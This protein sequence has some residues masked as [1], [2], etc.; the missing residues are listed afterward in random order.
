MA[1][2]YIQVALTYIRHPF[3]RGNLLFL[4]AAWSMALMAAISRDAHAVAM[5]LLLALFVSINLAAHMVEQFADSR[6]HLLPHFRRVHA[7][8]AAVA[9]FV[10]ITVLPGMLARLAGCSVVATIAIAV[11]L[12]GAGLWSLACR[13]APRKGDP[14][15]AI[16]GTGCLQLPVVWLLVL[17]IRREFDQF[18]SGQLEVQAI[19]LDAIVFSCTGL[20]MILLGA[21]QLFRLHDASETRFFLPGLNSWIWDMRGYT[22]WPAG[23]PRPD[24]RSVG[25]LVF[26]RFDAHVERL[27]EHARRAS[28]SRWSAVCR[29][30]VGT[31][32]GWTSWLL[33]VGVVLAMQ[34]A[35]WVAA[36]ER[37]GPSWFFW[38]TFV[39]WLIACPSFVSL[40]QLARRNYLLAYEIMLPVERRTYLKQV[41]MAAAISCLRTW[42]GMYAAFMLWWI[43]AA[44]E[45]LQIGLVVNVLACSALAQVGLFGIG[46]CLSWL[47]KRDSPQ[48]LLVVVGAIW[49]VFSLPM[50]TVAHMLNESPLPG[51]GNFLVPPAS[52]A[53]FAMF[54]LLLTWFVYRRWL[55][56][57]FD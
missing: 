1:N 22:P 5:L 19:I 54:G 42:G 3:R 20:V 32:N 44:L 40:G 35:A 6:A 43:T 52:A 25:R 51:L 13:F 33:G 46:L 37:L 29:W 36:G 41:G 31:A 9:T 4:F 56:E 2:P 30:R 39:V 57:D 8:V 17:I 28:A 15:L 50:L 27:I 23:L 49:G 18:M 14:L 24:E 10:V 12:F 11:S 16:V 45:P 21:V 55:V 26:S 7:V 38:L 48:M 53:L 47:A 34:F